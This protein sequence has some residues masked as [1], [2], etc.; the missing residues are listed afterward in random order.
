MPNDHAALPSQRLAIPGAGAGH[1]A[2]PSDYM[3]AEIGHVALSPAAPVVAG[4]HA[5]LELVFT[6]GRFGVDDTGSLRI[7]TRQVS[8][9]ARPQFTDPKAANYVSAEASNG[10]TLRLSFDPKLAMRP[11]SRTIT[12]TVERGFLAPGDTITVRLGD[13]RGGSPGLRMQT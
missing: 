1:T 2:H 7:C 12:I 5:S 3:A 11:W 9:L 4:S 13:R 6:A 10:A 8:D